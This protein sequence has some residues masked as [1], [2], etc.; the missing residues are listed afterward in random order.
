MA[1]GDKATEY[2]VFRDITHAPMSMQRFIH[3]KVNFEKKIHDT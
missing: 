3:V 1:V 2:G